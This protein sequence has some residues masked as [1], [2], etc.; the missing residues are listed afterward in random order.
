MARLPCRSLFSQVRSRKLCDP[1][2]QRG[3][4]GKILAPMKR[5]DLLDL[6]DALQHPGRQV[7]V[8]LET[9][10]PEE[11]ELD[12]AKPISGF[13]EAISTGNVLLIHG[14][15]QTR[16][17]LDCARC[18]GPVEMDVDYKM[19][20][21]FPVVGT[22]SC[23]AADDYARVAPDEEPYP[24]FEGNSLMV[25]NL[26]RQGLIVNLP[27]QPLCEFGWEGDCP[28]ARERGEKGAEAK[29]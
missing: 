13:L 14:E 23:F 3:P 8:D 10:L 2:T 11:E 22:P 27:M 7:A 29:P 17:T 21:E 9:E 19:D 28:Q 18:G 24:L 12:L 15:F 1:V 16:C 6:N 4:K 25:E 5:D 20:E 26:I